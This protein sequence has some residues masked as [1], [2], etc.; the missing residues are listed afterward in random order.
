MKNCFYFFLF[1]TLY[2]CNKEKVDSKPYFAFDEVGEKLLSELKLNDTLK[3]VGTNNNIQNY[4]IFKIDK[5]KEIVEDCGFTTGT[6]K[7][8]YYFDKVEFHFNRIDSVASL[9]NSPLTYTFTLQMQIP[10]NVD[11][12]NIPTDVKGK[13]SIFGNAFIGYNKIPS[14]TPTY[15]SPYINYPDFYTTNPTITYL[16]AVRTYIEVIVIKSGNNSPYVNPSYGYVSTINEVWF[17]KKYG[18]VLFKDI[19]GNE[20]KKIN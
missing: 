18:F 10:P 4:R 11:K 8:Y 2:S 19:Y 16:N 7:T 1:L 15:I 5:T 13:A 20:W 3:F 14:D 17:D 6:C 12:E 9:P